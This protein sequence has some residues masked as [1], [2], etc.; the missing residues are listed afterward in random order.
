MV[1]A[2]SPQVVAGQ[3]PARDRDDPATG[4]PA[5]RTTTSPDGAHLRGIRSSQKVL[6][7]YGRNIGRRGGQV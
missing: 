2:V 4:S 6:D 5:E 1:I 7:H 3:A